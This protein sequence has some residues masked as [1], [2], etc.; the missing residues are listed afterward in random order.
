MTPPERDEEAV[1]RFVE[2]FAAMLSDA[3]WQRMPARVFMALMTHDA[4]AMTASELAERLQ[5]SP[6]A[7]SGAV[8][9][10]ARLDL[11]A[12]ER[13]PGTRRDIYRVRD[14]AWHDAV[15]GRDPVLTQWENRFTEAL[16][17]VGPETPAGRR[18]TESVEFFTFLQRELGGMM[19]R[20]REYR[21]ELRAKHDPG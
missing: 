13:Q 9:Y 11:V 7:V 19:E 17:V 4:G 5:V 15:M 10:L 21:D 3:G 20:W 18:L 1:L 2:R 8:R 6:A 14:D 12:R 16:E